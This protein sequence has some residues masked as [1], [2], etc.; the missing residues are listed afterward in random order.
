[1]RWFSPGWTKHFRSPAARLM[2]LIIKDAIGGFSLAKVVTSGYNL[3]ISVRLFSTDKCLQFKHPKL[4]RMTKPL[5]SISIKIATLS[6]F[7]NPFSLFYNYSGWLKEK[8]SEK[9]NWPIPEA[10][11]ERVWFPVGGGGQIVNPPLSEARRRIDAVGSGG[12]H[13][14]EEER[15][16]DIMDAVQNTFQELIGVLSQLGLSLLSS[17]IYSLLTHTSFNLSLS[18]YIYI[19][20]LSNGFVRAS[21]HRY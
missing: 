5:H 3:M 21:E 14:G 20:T 2:T 17:Y 4:I 19:H 16:G 6:D 11:L 7:L 1:M 12:G 18:I 8:K 9:W 10:D 13:P 15:G